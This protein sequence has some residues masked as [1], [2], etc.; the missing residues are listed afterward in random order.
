MSQMLR[1]AWYR[2]RASFGRRW[3][4][5]LSVVLL[6]GSVGGVAMA[7]IAGA[8][9][10]E[11]SFR[12]FLASTNPSDLALITAIYHPEPTGY[13]ARLIQEIRHLPHVRRVESE[14]GY[15]AEEVG[16]S[17]HA[18]QSAMTGSGVAL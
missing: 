2:F 6:I 13:D 16:P 7:S 11:S 10:T 18:V 3:P 4:A 1:V 14:A 8:R 5:Y 12:Q 9:R 17:G 15:E